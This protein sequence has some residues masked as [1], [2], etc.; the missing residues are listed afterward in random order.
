L[1]EAVVMPV[2]YPF[3]FTGLL[4]PWQGILLYGTCFNCCYIV[5]IC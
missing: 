1:K 3:L 5:I 2:K 4:S